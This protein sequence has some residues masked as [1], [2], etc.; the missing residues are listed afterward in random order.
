MSEVNSI[1]ESLKEIK[2]ES[3]TNNFDSLNESQKSQEDAASKTLYVGNLDV[4]ADEQMIFDIF[5]AV[6]SV[7]SCK[8]FKDKHFL[9]NSVCYGFVEF[10][11]HDSAEAAFKQM[12]GRK[13][14]DFNIRV[15]WATGGFSQAQE[16]V[17]ANFQVYVGDLAPETTEDDVNSAFSGIAG[18]ENFKL[19]T[20]NVT[21][22]SKCYGFINFSSRDLAVSFI[23]D[24]SNLLIKSRPVKINWANN[25]NSNNRNFA[26]KKFYQNKNQSMD[27]D[28]VFNQTSPYNN[29]VYCG[30]LAS[31]T[32]QDH[33][34][35]LFIQ[36]GN[37]TD[38]RMQPN[39]GFA[40]VK[41]D[42]HE[43]ATTSIV[44]I[45]GMFLNGKNIICSWGKGNSSDNNNGGN[46]N[47]GNNNNVN[48][49]Y[50]IRSNYAPRNNYNNNYPNSG[51][52][53]PNNGNNYSNNGNNY[54][55]NGNNY[56]NNGNNYPEQNFYQNPEGNSQN[57]DGMYRNNYQGYNDGPRYRNAPNSYSNQNQNAE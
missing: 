3:S 36:Y 32:Q 50:R 42:S 34:L 27:Y 19:I 20:D 18:I 17:Q 43:N 55:N 52:N 12:D 8:I 23:N 54:P 15:N 6:A 31:F 49:N 45:N 51:N 11:D 5:S 2:L 53:Y 25:S 29:V 28:T 33:L 56:P 4:R 47:Y 40:F 14:F 21:G 1:T 13:I 57:V 10:P 26:N 16:K 37:V 22:E 24:S 9:K 30:N 35:R 7:S 46:N 48:N 41:M 39:R 44:N 38:I